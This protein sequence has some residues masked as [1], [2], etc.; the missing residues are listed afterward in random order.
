MRKILLPFNKTLYGALCIFTIF[1]L[2]IT[3]GLYTQIYVEH[4]SWSV[5]SFEMP[6]KWALVFT[7]VFVILWLCSR[8]QCKNHEHISAKTCLL[9]A[10]VTLPLILP[11]WIPW[12]SKY[13]YFMKE[14][15]EIYLW[16]IRMVTI[17]YPTIVF[18]ISLIICINYIICAIQIRKEN[19]ALGLN[20]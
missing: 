12:L 13:S 9:M 10:G 16:Y 18:V 19:K 1:Y 14:A 4:G 20:G 11:H 7:I 15:K 5:Y 3:H 6:M 8:Y 17:T 2:G